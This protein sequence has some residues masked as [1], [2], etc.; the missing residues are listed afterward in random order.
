MANGNYF[1]RKL[2]SYVSRAPQTYVN[3]ISAFSGGLNTSKSAHLIEK[4]E[5]PYMKNLMFENGGLYPR[6]SQFLGKY[7]QNEIVSCYEKPYY[8]YLGNPHL[9]Y[10][11]GGALYSLK[12]EHI[13]S[14]GTAGHPD[15]L[16]SGAD[17]KG[18]LTATPKEIEIEGSYDIPEV[19]GGVFF[20]FGGSLFY[21]ARGCYI[22]I[23]QNEP[24]NK[25]K[26]DEI[27]EEVLNADEN[28]KLYGINLSRVAS[29]GLTVLC[30]TE[31]KA[32]AFLAYAAS[33]G[34]IFGSTLISEGENSGKYR[35]IGTDK[36]H[37]VRAP[38][39][40]TFI[41]SVKD[42]VLAFDNFAQFLLNYLS[43]LKDSGGN[44]K[45]DAKQ[46]DAISEECVKFKN[47]IRD[48]YYP[49]KVGSEYPEW[50]L[51]MSECPRK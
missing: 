35:I 24:E 21:K 34:Y 48:I 50:F 41:L 28:N 51:G 6:M 23:K 29:G 19:R 30:E 17:L 22:K 33:E 43:G 5:T 10:C 8:S 44:S 9:I 37:A 45:Y 47:E 16:L 15:V 12:L 14:T 42:Y 49:A 20:E 1:T 36:Y 7:A 46:I 32:K 4:N 18:E 25:Y 26:L 27:F 13:S 39:S 40:Y 38:N 11:A 2:S 31:D 3:S